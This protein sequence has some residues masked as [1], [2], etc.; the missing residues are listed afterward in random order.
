[1]LHAT[2]V[3]RE[4]RAEPDGQPDLRKK[5]RKPVTS[6]LPHETYYPMKPIILF[7]TGKIA[8]VLLYFFTHHSDRQVV[9]C[10]VDRDYQPGPE[11]QGLGPYPW[12]GDKELAARREHAGHVFCHHPGLRTVLHDR[13]ADA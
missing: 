2:L 11:W 8:E 4:A 12:N 10:S 7:G 5:P 13:T 6:T 9:A 3:E 1:M